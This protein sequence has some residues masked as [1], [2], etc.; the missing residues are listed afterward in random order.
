M[1]LPGTPSLWPKCTILQHAR[2]TVVQQWDDVVRNRG[3]I[4]DMATYGPVREA[5]K[6]R[7]ASSSSARNGLIY[8]LRATSSE[9]KGTTLDNRSPR[10]LFHSSKSVRFLSECFSFCHDGMRLSVVQLTRSS[11]NGSSNGRWVSDSIQA[12]RGIL[13]RSSDA[14]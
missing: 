13:V 9:M 1:D 2:D 3:G 4:K 7:R 8:A 11:S 5:S 14:I 10:V 6:Y 12:S